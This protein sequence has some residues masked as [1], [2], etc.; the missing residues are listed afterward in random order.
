MS[1]QDRMLRLAPPPVTRLGSVPRFP[2]EKAASTARAAER[3]PEPADELAAAAVPLVAVPDVV[4]GHCQPVRR[5]LAR[6]QA[7]L[8][9]SRAVAQ[10]LA[11]QGAACIREVAGHA[12]RQLRQG[13]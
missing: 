11:D 4:S 1:H 2:A 10:T 7:V 12:T 9:A 5:V 3:V 6:Q 8:P 13:R